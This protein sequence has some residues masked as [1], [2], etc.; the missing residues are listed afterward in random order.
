M[1]LNLLFSRHPFIC[2]LAIV[3]IILIAGG[4]YYRP[5]IYHLVAYQYWRVFTDVESEQGY[6]DSG[7]VSL[8][9]E[10]HGQGP[11]LVLLH[12]GLTSMRVF[13][14][15]LPTLSKNHRVVSIDLRGQ[16]RSSL[17]EQPFTYRLLAQ[18]VLA[19]LD[20][21]KL[22]SVDLVGWS[23]GGIIGLMIALEQPSRVNHLVT[24][25][26]N[27]HPDGLTNETMQRIE[28]SEPS[29]ESFMTR[30]LYRLQ[31]PQPQRWEELWQRVN[32]LWLTRPTLTTDDLEKISIPTLVIVGEKDSVAL[33][34][35]EE[36]ALAMGD[37]RLIVVPKAGHSLL[38][39]Y[40]DL[41]LETIE[42]F[43]TPH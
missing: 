40:P 19:V 43:I 41:I 25:G 27:F 23:D 6:V 26:A 33:D 29:S 4:L 36:M 18:D 15:Q 1:S 37:A 32:L 11:T 21:L 35:A 2:A 22:S 42:D 16:G 30:L 34:H 14:G 20:A 39:Q 28:N 3:A 7:D 5:F 8:Y 12:G 9:Y 38:T 13:F 31:S 10:V 17:G 24:I